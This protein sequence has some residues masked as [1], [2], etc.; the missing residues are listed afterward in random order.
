MKYDELKAKTPATPWRLGT[1][2]GAVIADA[3]QDKA[4]NCCRPRALGSKSDVDYY[5]GHLIGESFMLPPAQLV[6]HWSQTYDG[7]LNTVRALVKKTHQTSCLLSHVRDWRD[8]NCAGLA[9]STMNAA[10]QIRIVEPSKEEKTK[11]ED[12]H[13]QGDRD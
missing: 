12:T 13:D 7:L 3:H 1:S 11:Q 2:D 10:E 6:V 5:G 4:T 8:C 9:R